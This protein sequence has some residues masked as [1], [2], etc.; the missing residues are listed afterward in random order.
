MKKF[1]VAPRYL[2]GVVL[3]ILIAVVST[4]SL[5]SAQLSP[6]QEDLTP[7]LGEPYTPSYSAPSV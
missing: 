1:R 3:A 6:T 4:V 2:W 5:V 7:Y